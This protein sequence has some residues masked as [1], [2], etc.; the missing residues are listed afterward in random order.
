MTDEKIQQLQLIE[1]NLQSFLMQK[2]QLQH[3]LHEI[4][5]ALS[6]LENTDEAYKIVGNVMISSDKETLVKDLNDKK[7]DF[8][9]RLDILKNQESQIKEKANNLRKE[10]ME[11]MEKK[12]E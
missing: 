1:Q 9:K 6:E 12:D 11:K 2:Q 8:N 7:T 3:E 5:S 4:D 10:V